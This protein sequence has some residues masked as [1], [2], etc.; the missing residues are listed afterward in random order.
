MDWWTIIR[1]SCAISGRTSRYL[2]KLS[3]CLEIM[4]L[5]VVYNNNTYHP[6]TG[7]GH[8][9]ESDKLIDNQDAHHFR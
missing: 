4:L 9:V 2:K 3:Y 8:I 6:H 7:L 1:M 5:F